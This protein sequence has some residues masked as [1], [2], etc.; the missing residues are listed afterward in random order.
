MVPRKRIF[1]RRLPGMDW[2]F[3]RANTLHGK[4]AARLENKRGPDLFTGFP[5]VRLL[6]R[7][8]LVPVSSQVIHKPIKRGVG[9]DGV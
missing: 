2:D 9:F 8:W 4:P 6:L 3:Y 7:R 1:V 5:S